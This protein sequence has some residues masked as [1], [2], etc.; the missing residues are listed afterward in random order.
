MNKL[1]LATILFVQIGM[2]GAAQCNV[3]AKS[4][5]GAWQA[6]G[7]WAFFEQMA[8]ESK[9]SQQ[10]FDSWLHERPEL[11]NAQWQLKAC[12]LTVRETSGDQ[13]KFRVELVRGRLILN[14]LD[15]KTK[16]TYRK[17]AA[18]GSGAR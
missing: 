3:S 14:S 5:V 10:T 11:M 4:V 1:G 17:I 9:G 7:Q 13:Q 2:A 15:G 12:T 18:D 16:S 8:F 6:V